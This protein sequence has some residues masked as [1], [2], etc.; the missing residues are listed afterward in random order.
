MTNHHLP[1]YLRTLR[2]S[3]GFSQNEIAYLLGFHGAHVSSF[4]RFRKKPGFRIAV[5]FEVIFRTSIS[6][7]FSGDYRTVEKAI[8]K[9]ALRLLKRL[10]EEEPDAKTQRKLAHLKRIIGASEDK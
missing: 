7:L 1:N 6:R 2:K 4:E 8:R 9:R 3:I 10:A 5:A